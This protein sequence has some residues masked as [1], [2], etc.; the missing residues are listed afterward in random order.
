MGELAAT[1]VAGVA[2]LVAGAF[3][4]L[5]IHYVSRHQPAAPHTVR[6]P[7][8]GAPI[9]WRDSLLVVG[10]LLRCGRRRAFQAAIPLRPLRPLLVELAMGT[11]WGVVALRLAAEG[12][13][14]AVPAYLTLA[15]VGLV[16]AI[17][18]TTTRLLPNRIT[19][20]A[21]PAVAALLL[22]ASLG[23]GDLGRFARALLAAAVVGAFFLLLALLSPLG[24]GDVKLALTLGLGLGWLSWGSVLVG[25]VAALVLGGLGGLVAIFVLGLPRKSLLPFG[26]WLVA[27]ALLGVLAG[28]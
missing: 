8:C 15:F 1:A 6:C 18:D 9:A 7:V 14:W 28:Q 26:P 25:V 4:N 10:R 27:G 17:I 20:P 16:L 21:F 23:L 5:V 24:L 12:L 3:A 13:G 19:Y 2:G 22:L 11:L